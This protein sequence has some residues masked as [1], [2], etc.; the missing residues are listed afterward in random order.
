MPVALSNIS[1]ETHDRERPGRDGI[2]H[3]QYVCGTP[4]VHGC[5]VE[6]TTPSAF[7]LA[8]SRQAAFT[9]ALAARAKSPGVAAE[10]S[11]GPEMDAAQGRSHHPDGSIWS[12]SCFMKQRRHRSPPR[13]PCEAPWW[14]V[15]KPVPAEPR[16]EAR[17]GP[18]AQESRTTVGR[19]VGFSD[20]RCCSVWR[21]GV[22]CRCQGAKGPWPHVLHR[23]IRARH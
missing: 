23:H 22:L 15:G 13:T 3:V 16:L 10:G 8:V 11:G 9:R 21:Y 19:R 18:F 6:G 7:D 2:S 14:P 5:A 4:V 12:T 20:A 1:I 17:Q